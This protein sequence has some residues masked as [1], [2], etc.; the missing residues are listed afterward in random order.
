M[1]S[2]DMLSYDACQPNPFKVNLTP[3]VCDTMACRA[4]FRCLA[5]SILFT[6]GVQVVP[7]ALEN[8]QQVLKA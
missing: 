2:Y 5:A 8:C 7:E 4:V 3:I 1:M 6:A